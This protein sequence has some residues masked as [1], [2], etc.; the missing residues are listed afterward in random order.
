MRRVT[1]K[2]SRRRSGFLSMELAMTLPILML[3]LL[4]VFEFSMLFYARGS[5]V[6]ASRNGARAATHPGANMDYVEQTVRQSLGP[7]LAQ[8][9]GIEA[10]IGPFSGDPVAVV[11][12]VPMQDAAPDLLWPIGFG[13]R[14]RFLVAETVM[15]RE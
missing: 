3:L 12:R 8:R 2:Q 1:Q 5:V 6:E 4:G 14:D 13:L 10:V 15:Q 9:V 11:V 7:V